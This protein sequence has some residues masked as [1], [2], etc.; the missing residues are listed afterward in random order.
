MEKEDTAPLSDVKIEIDVA[1]EMPQY[2]HGTEQHPH[3]PGRKVVAAVNMQS[4]TWL[5]KGVTDT[6]YTSCSQHS[7]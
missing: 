7:H 1:E 3:V 5:K 4:Y 6:R 2:W